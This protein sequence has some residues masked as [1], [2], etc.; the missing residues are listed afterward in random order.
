MQSSTQNIHCQAVK[1]FFRVLDEVQEDLRGKVYQQYTKQLP[2]IML[3]DRLRTVRAKMM[4]Y[5]EEKAG[6]FLKREP[7]AFKKRSI[8]W[9]AAQVNRLTGSDFFC[10]AHFAER[11]Q[12]M[13]LADGFCFEVIRMPD[14]KINQI[15][16]FEYCSSP[17]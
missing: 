15:M 13:L 11:P 17:R 9:H 4:P 10:P 1:S 2:Y 8:A 6:D 12:N 7:P 3:I 16:V 14:G 5:G